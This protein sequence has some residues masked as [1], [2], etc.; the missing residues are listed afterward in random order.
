MVF[1]NMLP[2]GEIPEV[3]QIQ[4]IKKVLEKL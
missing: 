3:E 2:Q 1:L 4:D